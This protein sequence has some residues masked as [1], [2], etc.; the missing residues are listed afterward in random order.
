MH[1]RLVRTALVTV[2]VAA[3][4]VLGFTAPAN[5]AGENDVTWTVRTGSNALGADRTSFTYTVNPGA[6]VDDTLVV[7]NRGATALDLA[8]YAADGYT[9][10]SGQLDL[11]TTQD[12]STG[13]GAW[14]DTDIDTVTVESGQTVDVPFS[15]QVPQDATPGDY[16]GGVVTSLAQSD[17]EAGINVDRRLGVRITLHVGGE[18]RPSLAVEDV[19]V[20]YH[21]TLNPFATGD[22]TVSYTLHNTGNAILSAQQLASVAGPFGWFTAAAAAQEA[23]PQLLPGESWDVTVPVEDVAPTFRVSAT[24]VVTPLLTDLSG[25]AT[26]L[27]AVTATDSTWAVPWSLLVLVLLVVGAVVGTAR[28]VRRRRRR[29]AE[30]ETARVQEAVE[31]ALRDRATSSS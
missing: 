15:V 22:A 6:A 11:L 5:A 1:A 3:L 29:R 23:P 21:G 20:A 12:T 2:G 26:S 10:E 8:V 24:A 19:S 16:V 7:A 18:L 14:V 17:E 13:V 28:V 9:T 25:S 31:L 27:D 30:Q 4:A